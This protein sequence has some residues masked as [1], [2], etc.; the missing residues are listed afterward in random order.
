MNNGWLKFLIPR[1][2]VKVDSLA[3]VARMRGS[4]VK[5]YGIRRT[6]DGYIV[7]VRRDTP[8]DLSVVGRQSIYG[9][10]L[11][12]VLPVA[13]VWGAL[14]LLLQFITIDYEIRGNLSP[15]DVLM[16]DNHIESHF[17]HIG[18]FAFL[19][20][21]NEALALDLQTVFH[22][23]IWIDVESQGSRLV[24]DIFD[25]Q[26][27]DT[28]SEAEAVDTIYARVSGEITHIDVIGCLVL[29]EPRQVVRKGE[30]LISCYTPTGYAGEV[31]PIA[32]VAAGSI[33][34]NVWYE[35]E[36][37]FPREYAVRMVTSN[38]QS[39]WFLNF[40]E[41]RVHVWGGDVHFEEFEE[42]SRVFNPLGAFNVSPISLERVHYYEKNDIMLNN[43]IEQ[44][45]TTSDVLVEEQLADL[46]EGE[47]EVVNLEF[48]TLDESDEMV[49]LVYHA[50]V[51]EDIAR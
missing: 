30:P 3:D 27:I 11:R 20:S 34:A 47:F 31:A 44:I 26:M 39:S 40:G 12:F 41:R 6:E 5:I 18:P 21:D 7:T 28:E 48:L 43:E 17:M 9:F 35:V 42:R 19:R 15:E 50:T 22:D 8:H 23:Y 45:R 51:R 16:V 1:V 36:I 33:Y 24:I 2:R 4:S 46:I 10:I 38:S 25:T 49:R 29:V 37:E 13:F 32:S 14:L